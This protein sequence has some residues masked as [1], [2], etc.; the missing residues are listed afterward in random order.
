MQARSAGPRTSICAPRGEQGEALTNPAVGT[1]N[2]GWDNE[3]NDLILHVG[4]VLE[5]TDL[6]RRYV[7]VSTLGAGTF[8]QVVKC[9]LQET[10]EEVAVKVIKNQQAFYCQARVEI[11]VLNFLNQRCDPHDRHHIVR[12]RDYFL[13]RRHLCLV[14][15][16]LSLNLYELVKHN[17]FRGLSMNLLRVFLSQILDAMVVLRDNSIIHCDLKPENVLLKSLDSGEIKVIDFGSA[18]F[19][20]RT[21]YAYIQSRF[22]RSPEVLLG[23]PYDVA[24]DMWSLGCMAAELFLG[25]PLFPGACEHDLL[26]HIVDMLGQPPA[27]VLSGAAHTSKYFRC[28]DEAADGG[29]RRTRYHL[30]S[31]AEFEA[32]HATKAPAGKRYFHHTRL[33]EII[34][35]YPVKASTDEGRERERRQ[36]FLDFLLGVLDLDP[37]TRWSPRQAAQ[38]PF[39]INKRFTG[40]YQPPPDPHLPM[41]VP[42]AAAGSAP[43]VAGSPYV[44]GSGRAA[45][46][47]APPMAAGM[48]TSPEAHATAHAAALAALQAH[49][50]P[51]SGSS[52]AAAERAPPPG[53]DPSVAAAAAAAA[54][55]YGSYSMAYR[56]APAG[57][58]PSLAGLPSGAQDLTPYGTPY[59]SLG[60]MGVTPPRGTGGYPGSAM[61]YSPM[62]GTGAGGSMAGTPLGAALAGRRSGGGDGGEEGA[63]PSVPTPS[64]WDPSYSDDQLLSEDPLWRASSASLPIPAPG[65]DLRSALPQLAGARSSAEGQGLVPG[66]G[67]GAAPAE[68]DLAAWLRLSSSPAQARPQLE[69][70][71]SSACAPRPLPHSASYPYPNLGTSANGAAHALHQLLPGATAPGVDSWLGYG[72]RASGGPR[73]PVSAPAPDEGYREYFRCAAAAAAPQAARALHPGVMCGGDGLAGVYGVQYSGQFGEAAGGHAGDG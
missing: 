38:H 47:Y 61:G 10:G 36:A 6:R 73:G 40:P 26:C 68:L 28:L 70:P 52:M 65:V 33:P 67:P 4:D 51:R 8:G 5:N 57:G 42:E 35:A 11:G 27:H 46:T 18:C 25:L 2:G 13:H 39:V 69:Q 56:G 14:F 32:L 50:S 15:E 45:Y 21:T 29:G 58:P 43:G 49:F 66:L 22:Y 71:R 3:A 16:L 64:D 44:G 62:S 55:R 54:A 53:V 1:A 9:R 59:G 63:G 31:Q 7:V 30:R 72:A 19:E 20:N 12:M 48:A 23:H 41:R 60:S 34:G 37:R 17:Q 24:I